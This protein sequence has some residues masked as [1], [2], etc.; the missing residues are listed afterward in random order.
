M[1]EFKNVPSVS[2]IEK[3]RQEAGQIKQ[4]FREQTLGYITAAFGL[5]A[6]LA[7]NEAI[8]S[9]IDTIFVLGKSGVWA[10]LI[11]AIIVT[12]ALVVISYYLSK[13][14]NK[15]AETTPKEK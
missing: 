12:I 1:D 6:G 3:A 14:I 15:E 4:K 11:Y 10:K 13:L 2:A 8:K 7:W 5:V 9:I